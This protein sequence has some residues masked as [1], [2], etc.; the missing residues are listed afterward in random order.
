M[1]N[2]DWFITLDSKNSRGEKGPFD[3]IENL[4]DNEKTSR[5][6]E[7]PEIDSSALR[8]NVKLLLPE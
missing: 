7:A 3:H 2:L 4:I 1:N 8:N 5:S 6:N